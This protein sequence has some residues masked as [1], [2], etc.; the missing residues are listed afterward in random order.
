[1]A[2]E[3]RW[4]DCTSPCTFIVRN[5]KLLAMISRIKAVKVENE[6]PLEAVG[7]YRHQAA[8]AAG[9]G[10]GAFLWRRQRLQQ[11]AVVTPD[12]RGRRFRRR[13]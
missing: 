8:A 3:S 7:L 11:I 5:G 4:L 2:P 10:N 12:Q 6:R 9:A 1:M 13:N